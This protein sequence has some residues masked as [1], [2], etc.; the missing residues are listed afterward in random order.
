MQL[1]R[2]GWTQHSGYSDRELQYRPDIPQ[3]SSVAQSRPA[4]CDLMDCSMPGLPVHDQLPEL[5]Q[6]HVHW[7]SDAIQ[8]SHPLSSPSPPAFRH[9]YWRIYRRQLPILK[10]LYQYSVLKDSTSNITLVAVQKKQRAKLEWLDTKRPSKEAMEMTWTLLLKSLR[11]FDTWDR[12]LRASAL[13]WPWGM[14]WGGRWEGGSGWGTHVHP[15]LIHVNAR[16]KPL[17]Y[18]TIISIQLK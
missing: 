3:F 13:G 18:C 17:Q 5:A 7:V 6:T 15:W 8:P 16:Q 11:E 10:Q 1:P 9:T 2:R 12:A 14:G 4:L